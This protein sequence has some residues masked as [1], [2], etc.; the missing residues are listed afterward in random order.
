MSV[1]LYL[2]DTEIE[3]TKG[4]YSESWSHYQITGQ[5]EAGT[6][7]RDL[8]RSNILGLSVTL[9]ATDDTKATIEAFNNE[10]SLTAQYYSGDTLV[11][12]EAYMDGL[13]C[14]L[15]TDGEWEITFNLVDLEQ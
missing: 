9:T 6:N 11:S 5:T 3:L 4:S 13:S 2:N 7:R 10:A 1:A 15:L 14:N 12:W 8:I